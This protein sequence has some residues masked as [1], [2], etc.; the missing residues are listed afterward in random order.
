MSYSMPNSTNAILSLLPRHARRIISLGK[1]VS[2]EQRARHQ[3]SLGEESP[4]PTFTSPDAS[5]PTELIAYM[6]HR[7]TARLSESG[8]SKSPT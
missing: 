6:W 5:F 3:A 8:W 7:V 4:A 1:D 2:R